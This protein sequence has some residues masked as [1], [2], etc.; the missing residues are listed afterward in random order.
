MTVN[1]LVKL[2]WHSATEYIA[3]RLFESIEK[4]ELVLNNLLNEE[5]LIM[6]WDRKLKNNG[7]AVNVV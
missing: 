3:N 6:K 5:G 7:N 4:L 1:N 2:V